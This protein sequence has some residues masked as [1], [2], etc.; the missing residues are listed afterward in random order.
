MRISDAEMEIINIIWSTNQEMTSIE[1]INLLKE[2][3]KPT[4]VKTFL[5]R[6]SDKGVLNVRR[7][8]KIN[9][10]SANI[11]E[12]EYKQNQT[13]EFLKEFHKGSVTSLLTALVKGKKTDSEEFAQIKKWFDEL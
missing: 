11:S 4:T 12:D 2:T 7:K 6:L 13:E 9:F 3:W 8:G 1:L 5:K 10:Y